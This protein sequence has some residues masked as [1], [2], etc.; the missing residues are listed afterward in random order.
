VIEQSSRSGALDSAAEA[1]AHARYAGWFHDLDAWT[2][3]WDV[4]HPETRGRFYFGDG[5]GETGLLTRFLPRAEY[6]PPWTA[7]TRMA[8]QTQSHAVFHD[9]VRAPA[10]S[11]AVLE[12]DALVG[13]LFDRHFGASS[14]SRVRADLLEAMLRFATDALPPATERAARISEDDWRKPTAG[15]H[16][17]DSDGMWFAWALQLE[18]AHVILGEADPGHAR[19]ALLL[20]GVAIGCAANFAW[21]GHRCTRAEYRRDDRTLAL[22]R[23]RGAQ[24]AVDFAAGAR[25]VHA[26]YRI[27]EWRED[28]LA[29]RPAGRDAGDL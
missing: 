18:A 10:V 9:A 16:T 2:E 20:A 27:R 3:Y 26:L 29:A 25:E 17:L 1:A 8:L 28:N 4:Y 19:R 21:R 11:E 24:W 5:A 15:R 13:G 23:A 12:V 14:N 6:P 22:L 7:W